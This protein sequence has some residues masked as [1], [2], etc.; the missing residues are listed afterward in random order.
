MK[1]NQVGGFVTIEEPKQTSTAD[2]NPCDDGATT[3]SYSLGESEVQGLE[4]VLAYNGLATSNLTFPLSATYT[5]T[6]AEITSTA[7]GGEYTKG[8]Q[9]KYIPE[10]QLA[11]TAGV[12]ANRWSS[13]LRA[14]YVS[15]SCTETGCN[16]M[17]DDNFSKTDDLFV[18]DF[19]A[20]FDVAA[21]TST[22]VK[23]DN[24]LDEQAIVSRSPYG[25][26][27]NK[28]RTALVG[29]DFTF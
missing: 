23:V 11:L 24:I 10:N 21:N 6:D 17:D 13:H 5:Y 1:A 26:R 9:I 28:P 4:A 20:R 16:Q 8:D 27:G 22:Y 15:S 19:V 12:V 2:A 14:N 3:G 18:I 7:D 29:V 25:A